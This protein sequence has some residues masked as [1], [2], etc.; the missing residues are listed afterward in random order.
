MFEILAPFFIAIILLTITPGVD[1]ALILRTAMVGSKRKALNAGLGIACGC[2]V[3]GILIALGV[4]AILSASEWAF[5]LMKYVGALY[6]AWLGLGL[7]LKP[8][9]KIETNIAE[10]QQENWF[11]S[12]FMTNILN[13]KVGIFYISFLPQF[14]PNTGNS[15][16][17]LLSLVGVHIALGILWTLVLIASM[18]PISKFIHQEGVLKKIDQITGSIFILFALKLASTNR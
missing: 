17:W 12:G 18:Q 16:L 1:T 13:P 5:N 9:Q 2:L 14:V 11:I 7:L 15:T 4:G 6:L 10:T 8:R 3:W